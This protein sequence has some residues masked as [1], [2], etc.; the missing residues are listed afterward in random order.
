MRSQKEEEEEDTETI[1]MRLSTIAVAVKN[2]TDSPL[3][4]DIQSPRKYFQRLLWAAVAIGSG[5]PVSSLR[6]AENFI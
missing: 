2:E 1:L 4:V 3:N 6:V 5:R